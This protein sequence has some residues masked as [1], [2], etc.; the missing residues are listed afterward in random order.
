MQSSPERDDNNIP[1]AISGPNDDSLP[2]LIIILKHT[3]ETQVLNTLISN[4][5]T[6]DYKDNIIIYCAHF[7]VDEDSKIQYVRTKIYFKSRS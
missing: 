5:T 1:T 2:E 6:H 4:V 7:V 3:L